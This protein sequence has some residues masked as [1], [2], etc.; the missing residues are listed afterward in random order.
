LRLAYERQSLGRTKAVRDAD[1]IHSPHYTMPGRSERPV[2]VTVHDTT[3]FTHPEWHEK[4]KV[5]LFTRAIQRAARDA[6]VV[7]AVSEFTARE[8]RSFVEVRRPVIVAPHGVDLDRFN[9]HGDD[10]VA[11]RTSNLIRPYALFVGTL[12]PRKGVDVLLDAFDR[13]G[14]SN[15]DLELWIV[16]QKGWHVDDVEKRIATHQYATRIRQ[17]GYV[18]DAVLPSLLRHARVVAYPS[19]G[20]GFGLP[21]LEAMACGAPTI[22]T[23]DTVMA[24]LAGNGATTVPV[25]DA[26][27]LADAILTMAALDG[28]DRL[29]VAGRA[30]VRAEEFS[31]AHSIERH[32][33]A[34]ELAVRE[35]VTH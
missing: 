20:E 9:P 27:A 7:V 16:G 1:V 17:L 26:D 3:Y 13:V 18:E 10:E 15:Q 29:V 6:S 31:W 34:Y 2:V 32:Q 25:G 8:L 23:A 35:G 28:A 19:R 30:R 11:R 14:A 33:E 5:L 21:V 12:E 22:T 24:E 4:S